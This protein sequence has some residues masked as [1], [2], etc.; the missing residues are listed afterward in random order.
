MY[1]YIYVYIYIHIY[2]YIFIYIHTHRVCRFMYTENGMVT[3]CQADLQELLLQ[4]D[5]RLEEIH[6]ELQADAL[7]GT[8]Y[9]YGSI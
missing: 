3:L 1:I 7:R 6:V 8:E 2:I 4:H 5:R 9:S